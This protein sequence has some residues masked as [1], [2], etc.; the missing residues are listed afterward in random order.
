MESIKTRI[1][2]HIK[3]NPATTF[4]ELSDRIEGFNGELCV[5]VPDYPNIVL[6]VKV[7]A[8]AV[9]AILELHQEKKIKTIPSTALVYL[10]DG[11]G[12]TLP[13]ARQARQYKK[14]HWSPVVFSVIK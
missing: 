8:E 6:W 10:M 11:K 7:S 9:Q 4:A 3:R 13:I 14:P 2:E 1:H 5:H 12:L